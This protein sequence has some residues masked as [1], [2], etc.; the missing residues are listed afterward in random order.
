MWKE[1]IA[2]RINEI[3]NRNRMLSSKDMDELV[4]AHEVLEITGFFYDAV[5]IYMKEHG[6]QEVV[7]IGCSYG[8]QSEAFVK[9]NLAYTGIERKTCRKHRAGEVKYIHGIYPFAFGNY[10]LA[11][12]CN[13]MHKH[14]HPYKA[15]AMDFETVLVDRVI[16]KK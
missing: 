9:N 2:E 16:K 12:L 11:V 15:L 14:F 3:R 13:S 8:Y 7:D 4:A 5:V 10:P 1:I 6:I